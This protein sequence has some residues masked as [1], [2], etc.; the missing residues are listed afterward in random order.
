MIVSYG[1][2][3]VSSRSQEQTESRF[4]KG[5]WLLDGNGIKACNSRDIHCDWS[6]LLELV[7]LDPL[8]YKGWVAELPA[9]HPGPDGEPSYSLSPTVSWQLFESPD[10]WFG[11]TR[12]NVIYLWD[13]HLLRKKNSICSPT[14][15]QYPFTSILAQTFDNFSLLCI[16]KNRPTF[17]GGPL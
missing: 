17:L 4:S 8:S 15:F 9:F 1:Q 6:F 13:L 12:L 5:Q 11:A 14:L 7:I 10:K 2:E 3:S 16:V